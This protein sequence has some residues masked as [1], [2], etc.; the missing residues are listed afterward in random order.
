MGRALPC[1]ARLLSTFHMSEPARQCEDIALGP[2]LQLS[3]E[4][5]A[6]CHNTGKDLGTLGSLRPSQRTKALHLPVRKGRKL[7]PLEPA[8]SCSASLVMVS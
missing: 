1:K 8:S 6:V 4:A 7:A 2:L 5:F 3:V